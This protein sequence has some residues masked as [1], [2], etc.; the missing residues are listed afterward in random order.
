MLAPELIKDLAEKAP[1]NRSRFFQVIQMGQDVPLAHGCD[2]GKP[3]VGAHDKL[4]ACRVPPSSVGW[5]VTPQQAGR[6]A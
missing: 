4:R 6:I 1:A 3:I 5:A 2:T